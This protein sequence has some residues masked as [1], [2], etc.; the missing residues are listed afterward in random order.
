MITEDEIKRERSIGGTLFGILDNQP[1]GRSTK[2]KII[3][4]KGGTITVYREVWKKIYKG[5]SAKVAAK[6]FNQK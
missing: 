4:A 6:K 1:N 2:T 5:R 3:L